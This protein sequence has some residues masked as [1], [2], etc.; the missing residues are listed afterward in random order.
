MVLSLY[1]LPIGGSEYM[2]EN[3]FMNISNKF[4]QQ[5]TSLRDSLPLV[6]A[7][8]QTANHHAK[9]KLDRFVEKHA[10]K[11]EKLE[12]MVKYLIKH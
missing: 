2:E 4:I 1:E 10:I 11:T 8:L 3:S 5:I 12:D 6:K 9:H 7:N